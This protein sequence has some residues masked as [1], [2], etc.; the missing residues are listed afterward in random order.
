MPAVRLGRRPE[1]R[2]DGLKRV[3]QATDSAFRRRANAS[4][5]GPTLARI[6]SS[7]LVLGDHG[8]ANASLAERTRRLGYRAI[9]AKTAQDAI[10]LAEERGFRFGVAFVRSDWP[11]TDLREAMREIRQRSRSPH[12]KVIAT[13]DLPTESERA[14]LRAAG[15]EIGLWEPLGDHAL[16][17]HLNRSMSPPGRELLRSSDRVPTEWRA[18][19]YSGGRA[20][21]ASVY[22]LSCGGAFLATQRPSQS[23]VEVAVELA[24]PEGPVSVVG[25]VIYTNVPGNL[26]RQAL[27]HGMAVRFRDVPDSEHEALERSVDSSVARFS[28]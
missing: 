24:L 14:E 8:S 10:E 7:V 13:G 22:S 28:I 16:R 21:P 12:L 2:S 11:V 4:P 6:E 27:P 5:G 3:T 15:I 20:K 23:G 26:Q 1:V 17:F 18:R 19:V 9:R 25:R